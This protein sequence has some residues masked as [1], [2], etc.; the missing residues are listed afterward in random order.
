MMNKKITLL[1]LLISLF[2]CFSSFKSVPQNE[3]SIVNNSFSVMQKHD[4]FYLEGLNQKFKGNYDAAHDLF[5]YSLMVREE[6]TALYELA[7]LEAEMGD[8]KGAVNKLEKVMAIDSTNYWYAQSLVALYQQLDRR[9]EALS[10]TERMVEWF[11]TKVEVLFALLDLYGQTEDYGNMLQV[12]DR[13]EE[14]IGKSEQMSMEKFRLYL[15]FEEEGK[16]LEEIKELVEEYPNDLRYYVLL[17]D[18]FMQLEKKEEAYQIYQDVLQEE[19]DNVMALLS[20]ATYY[21][22]MEDYEQYEKQLDNLLSNKKVLPEIKISILRMIISKG[23]TTESDSLNIANSFEKALSADENEEQVPLFYAQYLLSKKDNKAAKPLLEKVVDLNPVNKAARLMLLSIV[24]QEND[25]EGIIKV[26]EPGIIATPE[27]I[28]FYFY[29][30]I[31]YN[32]VGRS[33]E[34][35]EISRK[36]LEQVDESTPKEITSDFYAIMGDVYHQQ[37]K[38]EESYAAY[39]SALVY[40]AENIGVLNNYAYFLSEENKNLDKAEEMSY[41]TIKAEPKNSTYL[42]TYAWILFQKGKYAEAKIYIDDALKNGGEESEV[43]VEHS[44]DIYYFNGEKEKALEFW[45]QAKEL[46]GESELLNKKI[47]KRKYYAK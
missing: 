34:T 19:P 36:A 35:I 10:L 33:E 15:R 1:F 45:I 29:L 25:F 26:C 28:E 23:D 16:A 46:G 40:N 6:P 43:I 5:A 4:Y 30:A 32:Q 42:D 14:K 13:I 41:K 31:A 2:F 47:K 12:L 11:P 18:V 7:M 24:A 37:S 39:D 38:T 22:K 17:G 20:M 8:M 27:A 21:E 44:G 9:E 3:D